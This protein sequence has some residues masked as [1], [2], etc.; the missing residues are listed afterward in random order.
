M[1][2]SGASPIWIDNAQDLKGFLA[3]ITPFNTLYV[4]L[5]G[6]N[7]GRYGTL[8]I[9]TILAMP[10]KIT[11]LIDVKTLGDAAFTTPNGNGTKY[12]LK[13]ILEELAIAKHFWDVRNDA[14][15]LWSH[16]QIRLAGVTDVQLFENASRPGN[17]THLAGLDTCAKRDLG[18]SAA[19]K[20]QWSKIKDEV[21]ALMANDV[22][23][24]RPLCAKAIQYCANDVEYLPALHDVYN[25]RITRKWKQKAMNESARRVADSCRAS[26]QPNGPGKQFGPWGNGGYGY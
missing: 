19:K 9:I 14:D 8:T 2:S 16:H 7:L 26:Y 5:E 6:K 3:Q 11:G 23:S 17:K 18:W 1:A 22:F 13:V 25:R 10:A 12:N 24:K 4:D 15:A 21:R 20:Q